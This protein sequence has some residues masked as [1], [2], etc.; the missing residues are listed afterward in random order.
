MP[1]E[2]LSKLKKLIKKEWK[3][4][5]LSAVIIG[6]LTHMYVFTNM[7]PNHDG[8]INI[9][10]D[11]QKYTSGRFFLSPFS[12]ISSFFDLPWINGSISVLYL[13]LTAVFLTEFFDLHKRLAIILTAGLI[14]TF[15]TIASTFSYM[16][17]ADGY[18]AGILL[19]VLSVLITKKYRFGFFF[20]SIIL[21]LSIGIYQANL[22]IVLTLVAVWFIRELIS[23]QMNNKYLFISLIKYGGMF[24]IGMGLYALTFK[25]YQKVFGGDISNYQGLDQIGMGEEGI[26]D[27]LVQIKD[28]TLEFFFRGLVTNMSIN[29][30]EILNIL[31]IALIVIGV[32]ISVVHNKVYFSP[33]RIGLTMFSIILLPIFAFILYFVSPGVEYHMLMVMA[34]VFV[35]LLPIIIYD[36]LKR[37]TF[38]VKWFSWGSISIL[39]LITFNFALISNIA[40]F[41]MTLKYE[42]SY[43]FANRILDRIEQTDGYKN[44]SKLAIIGRKPF[45]TKMGTEIVPNSIPKMTGAMGQAS[46]IQP[47]HY[48]F[49]FTNYFGTTLES[50]DEVQLQKLE[51][52]KLVKE[53]RPWPANDS[54][55]VEGDVVII[56][57]D[58]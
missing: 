33:I 21:Y 51:E 28:T 7:L 29:L 14:V 19:A 30:F 34:L 32:G 26:A 38:P 3:I 27:N 31:L 4:A 15:P 45:P 8:L 9:Y 23:N 24:T 10:S 12:G 25:A 49:M 5:F 41:N 20:S 22:T 47:Y 40:Y 35:Y 58:E 11:Q 50:V 6:F 13:A 18:M 56:K 37:P 2:F 42:R 48:S 46:L 36:R 54:V 39:L 16:F 1:E 44:V 53:M 57:L 43:A 55:R 17:T 52:S